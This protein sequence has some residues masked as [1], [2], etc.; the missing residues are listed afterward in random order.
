MP[1]Q[2]SS[3]YFLLNNKENVLVKRPLAPKPTFP[4]QST[5]VYAAPSTNNI[6]MYSNN[7]NAASIQPD[8]C[9]FYFDLD[10]SGLAPKLTRYAHLIGAVTTTFPN[11]RPLQ[12]S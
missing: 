5:Q 10:D 1:A 8:K 6:S 3:G 9:T 12:H 4:N 11:I 2:Q 7:N